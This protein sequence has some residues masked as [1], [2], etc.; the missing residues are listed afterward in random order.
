MTKTRV[1][2]Y[3]DSNTWG[4]APD[5]SGRWPDDVRWT[6]VM[7]AS[8]GADYTVLDAGLGGRTTVFDDPLADMRNGKLYLPVSLGTHAPLDIVII[9]LGTNDLKGYYSA[10]AF[11]IAEGAG[12]LAEMV[13]KCDFGRDGGAPTPLMVCPPP[14]APNIEATRWA[15]KFTGGLA[16]SHELAANY[17]RVAEERGFAF[18]DAG[19]VAA[20]SPL[21]SVHLSAEAHRSLGEALAAQVRVL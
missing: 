18:F 2:C 1:L 12:L 11:D 21:D 6:G 13:S 15:G 4:H 10:S 16:K 3:G 9:M 8:L 17:E 19:K 20:S 5:G 14:L 7:A